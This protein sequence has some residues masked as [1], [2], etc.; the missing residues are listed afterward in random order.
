MSMIK[1]ADWILGRVVKFATDVFFLL[2]CT[3][4]SGRRITIPLVG[5]VA[6]RR[7]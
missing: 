4:F 6:G 5:G 3:L 1:L 7:S 2:H